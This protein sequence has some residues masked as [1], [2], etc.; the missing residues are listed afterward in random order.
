M[1]LITS[2]LI[3]A[4]FVAAGAVSAIAIASHDAARLDAR[5]YEW[6]AENA[7]SADARRARDRAAIPFRQ[8]TPSGGVSLDVLT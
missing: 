5:T 6:S 7:F 2:A 3:A 4:S 1:S 8:G